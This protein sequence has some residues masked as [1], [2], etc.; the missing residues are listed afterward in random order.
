[1][2]SFIF[3][4]SLSVSH[5]TFIAMLKILNNVSKITLILA[6]GLILIYRINN[7][8]NKEIS[9]D[10]LGYYLYL[11]ATFVYDQPMLNDY[12]WLKKINNEKDLTRPI[13]QVTLNDEGEPMY[14]FLMGMSFF[15]LPFFFAGH[16]IALLNGIPADGFSLPYQYAL[17]LGGIFYTILGLFF[18]WKILRHF[19]SEGISALVIIIIVFATNYIHHLTL[20]NLGTVNVLFMLLS[21]IIW[22]TIRWHETFKNKH[23]IVVGMGIVMMGLVKPSEITAI[24]IFILWG[25]TSWKSIQEKLIKLYEKK[26]VILV[27]IGI[28]LVMA[29]P[30]M[31][32]WYLKTGSPIYDS[33]K[34]PGVGLDFFSPHIV[35]ALF[36][37]RKGWL[38]YTPVM[39]FS[40]IGFN[41]IYRYN[42]RIFFALF[43]YWILAFYIVVSWSEW[44]YGA[45]YSNRAL[46][47]T[48]PI[49]AISL[50]YFLSFILKR[51]K[52]YWIP[53]IL[54]MC[55]LLCLNQFKWWQLRNYILDPYRTTKA[56][57]WAT[58]LKTSVSPE[59]TKLLM[60]ERDSRGIYNFKNEED[61]TKKVLN[62]EIFDGEVS[63]NIMSES[64][65][66]QY[67]QLK[68]DQEYSIAFSYKFKELTS[69][70]HVWLRASADLRYPVGFEG[71]LP[72]L[73]M[74]MEHN[75]KCYGYYAPELKIDS[76]DNGWNRIVFDYLTP[77]PVRTINDVFKCYI[78]KRGKI[79]FDID[80]FK[81][82]VFERTA[83]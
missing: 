81:L 72:S 10:V 82:E 36:S 2:I 47:T 27:T 53:I 21:I 51:P 62:F 76:L 35:K 31:I 66:N 74:T 77:D 41:F 45:A 69:T 49:L 26:A 61:Y 50:G 4:K 59:D 70:D 68:N 38:L 64:N 23:L 30:Q 13:Y 18:L 43:V 14:F 12:S 79:G 16:A 75:G 6:C 48:Y 15:Y 78:W 83:K 56:Y 9:W 67:Y 71:P 8:S 5:F 19:F 39:I 17:V 63:E 55:L 46:I 1:V 65:G 3:V 57:Y 33:Y 73:V 40:L 11:P 24:I 28:G 22:N 34:N 54:I 42:K 44:W 20:D 32:Y 58:F 25:V 7:V 52:I 29:L 37:Y 60:V 80:N